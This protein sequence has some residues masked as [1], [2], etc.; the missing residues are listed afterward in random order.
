M[1]VAL[2]K[3]LHS[4]LQDDR[5]QTAQPLLDGYIKL[6][7]KAGRFTSK[8]HRLDFNQIP[9]FGQTAS[10][11]LPRK[12]H[13]VSRVYL[14][15]TMPDITTLQLKVQATPNFAGPVFRWTNSLGHAIINETSVSIGGPVFD[16]LN[17][18]LLEVLD[19]FNTPLEKVPLV[20]SLIQREANFN[21]TKL[22]PATN[23]VITPLPFWFSRGDP[24]LWLPIDAL[25]AADVR[26]DVKFAPWQ[27]LY[28]TDSRRET[29][30]DLSNNPVI[31][32]ATT[33]NN[34]SYNCAGAE[35]SSLL[36]M[37]S[38]QFFSFDPDGS[39]YY[40]L[41]KQNYPNG[42]ILSPIPDYLMP[43]TFSLGDTYIMAEYIYLDKTEANRFRVSNIQT[44][45]VQH[46]TLDPQDTMKMNQI[47]I[48]VDFSNP[49]RDLFFF[50]QRPEATSYNCPFLA[51]R[52]LSGSEQ[53]YA[54]W[55]PDADI[56]HLQPAF[57]KSDSEPL[58]SLNFVYE[59]Q[60][61]RYKTTNMALFR[62]ILPAL[63]QKK[64]P[65]YNRYFYNMSF[66]FQHGLTAPSQP[67]GEANFS[68][69][70]NKDLFLEI[71]P[72]TGRQGSLNVNQ[73]IIYLFAETYNILNIYG[74][75]AGLLFNY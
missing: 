51:T 52:D 39:T 56:D 55:W 68:V 21:S 72:P 46:Y 19:E 41:S 75:R 63:E 6:F 7:R 42:L 71:R 62:S 14:V 30:V 54:P 8:W 49:I 34:N 38:S 28:Y 74:G 65:F 70:Q 50:C 61:V 3:P 37:N 1:V 11:Y 48:K 9:Q 17:G 26:I 18:R 33:V 12:G 73:F 40:N 2:L 23:E 64:A 4:G 67:M 66:G 35:Y 31:N 22:P 27:S 36:P 53:P 59:G 44:P 25:S 57:V 20:D 24:A 45:I 5:L 69:I 60:R 10:L 13:L 43:D 15:S 29:P 58:N 47:K 16:K 32:T